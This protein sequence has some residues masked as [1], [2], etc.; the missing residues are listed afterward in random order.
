VST[1]KDIPKQKMKKISATRIVERKIKNEKKK[2]KKHKMKLPCQC[3]QNFHQ[4]LIK[5]QLGHDLMGLPI[6]IPST[7]GLLI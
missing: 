7:S 1:Q 6:S 5:P 4:Q 2:K 3:K